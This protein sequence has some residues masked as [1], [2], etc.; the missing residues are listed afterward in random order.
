[1]AVHKGHSQMNIRGVFLHVLGDALG[2]VVV[3]VSALV[4]W[5]SDWEH[6]EVCL[7]FLIIEIRTLYVTVFQVK[8]VGPKIFVNLLSY[9]L[10]ICYE[11]KF[12]V[13]KIRSLIKLKFKAGPVKALLFR[14]GASTVESGHCTEFT[15]RNSN[16]F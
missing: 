10:K 9:K 3:I 5:L 13:I 7:L 16:N 4:V 15:L 6:K 1:V 2:S 11:V 14:L 8:S 12:S